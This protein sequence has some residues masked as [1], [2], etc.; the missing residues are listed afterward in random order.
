MKI[1]NIVL[2]VLAVVLYGVTLYYKTKGS[3]RAIVAEL[4]AEIE[5]TGIAGSEKMQRVVDALYGYVPV[6]LK[7]LFSKDTL[8]TLAQMIFDWMRK[9]AESYAESIENGDEDGKKELQNAMLADAIKAFM[10]MSE[11]RLHEYAYQ[12]GVELAPTDSKEVIIQKLIVALIT[13]AQPQD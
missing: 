2:I 12:H 7:P 10:E 9:Y 13:E 4:I 11:R 6:A 3:L 5:E 8:Q 1:V